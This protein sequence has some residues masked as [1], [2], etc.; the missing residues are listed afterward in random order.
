VITRVL[1]S[2]RIYRKAVPK[3]CGG[4]RS[5]RNIRWRNWGKGLEVCWGSLFS[6]PRGHE[7]GV[8]ASWQRTFE[9]R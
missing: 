7:A 8:R 3:G 5:W 2:P 6:G 1:V 9:G 4:K